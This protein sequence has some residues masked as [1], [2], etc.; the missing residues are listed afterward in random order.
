MSY[1]DGYR[2]ARKNTGELLAALADDTSRKMDD[3]AFDRQHLVEDLLT[4]LTEIAEAY[5]PGA[6]ELFPSLNVFHGSTPVY[7]LIPEEEDPK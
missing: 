7:E 3:E 4:R 5:A 6:V 1:S 2:V